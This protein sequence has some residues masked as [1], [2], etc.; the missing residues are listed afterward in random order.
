MREAHEF[1]DARS[2]WAFCLP[3]ALAVLVGQLAADWIGA[4]VWP[5]DAPPEAGHAAVVPASEDRPSIRDEPDLPTVVTPPMP[6]AAP[7]PVEPVVPPAPEAAADLATEAPAPAWP[8][9]PAQGADVDAGR[10]LPGPVTARQ[11][12][13]SESCINNTVATRNPNGWE[14]ALENDAP[15]RCTAISP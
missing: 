12:G 4:A 3:V 11:A 10:A 13:A 14:Q 8:E 6:V 7:T 1:R 2:P 9:T 15:V 5:R